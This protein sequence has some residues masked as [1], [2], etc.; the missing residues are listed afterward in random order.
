MNES[1][2]RFYE[3]EEVVQASINGIVCDVY[4]HTIHAPSLAVFGAGLDGAL[5]SMV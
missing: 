3:L 4:D 2:Q 1:G 5:S